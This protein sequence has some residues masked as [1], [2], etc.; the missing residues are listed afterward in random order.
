MSEIK[1]IRSE[2]RSAADPDKATILL[3]FFKTGPGQ[4]GEG[5]R[6]LGVVMPKIR[7]IVKSHRDT[8]DKDILL[9]LSS[10]FHEERMTA[11]LILDDQYQ[12]GDLSRKNT[13]YDLYL[14][15]AP[16][17]NNWDL[18]DLTAQYIIG[19]HLYGNDTSILTKLALSENLWERR[20]AMLSTFHFIRQGESQEALCIAEL[21]IH[22]RHDLIHKAV[23][24]MLR[25]IG[26]RCSREIECRFLDKH[27]AH[28]PRTMVR[29]AIEHFPDTLK[30]KY[31]LQS[32]VR[33]K[34][35]G[36]KGDFGK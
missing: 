25:E 28:M 9:L 14:A 24:W 20:I 22:D 6:F 34:K 17:I 10:P 4:Y 2:L 30:R 5:D 8:A 16:K 19:A 13:I 26:K 32:V 3:R 12:R 18:V 35:A 1:E 21:L 7:K 27:A 15:N 33:S 29:Y 23:G 36:P 31:S 11:L